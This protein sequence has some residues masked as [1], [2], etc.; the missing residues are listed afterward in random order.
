MKGYFF[1][2]VLLSV[3]SCSKVET[4]EEA[5]LPEQKKQV[6]I[7]EQTGTWCGA[8]P[9]GANVLRK[10][11]Q[12]FESSVVP[13]AIHGGSSDPMRISCYSNFRSDRGYSGFPSFYITET[14]YGSNFNNTKAAVETKLAAPAD[15]ALAFRM[16]DEGDS[17]VFQTK[18]AFYSTLSGSYYLSVYVTEDS[19]FGGTGSGS[20]DQSGAG[21]NYYHEHVLRA[22]ST[23][24]KFWGEE[25]VV[26]PNADML[27]E[28]TVKI[29]RNTNWV[30][31]HLKFSAVLWKYDQTANRKYTYINAFSL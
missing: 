30:D 15:A 26:D 29:A 5:W 23:E 17:L 4:I 9:G 16:T 25:L 14:R 3:V 10:L 22:T 18:T 19:I 1:L 21:A 7:M 8:C 28:K 27:L 11:V 12:E 31:K 6:V 20:Y 24:G 13:L 2:M